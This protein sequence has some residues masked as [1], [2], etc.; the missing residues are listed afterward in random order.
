MRSG[1]EPPA[2][3]DT[4]DRR[5]LAVAILAAFVAFLDGTVITVALP[6][7]SAELGGGL[8]VQQWVVDAYLITL[9]ALI[10]LAGSLSDLWGRR[11]VLRLGLWG[12]ALT[13]LL[14]G[15]APT[16][17][18][19]I[20][21][22]ALQ[23]VAGA[24]LVPS[25][26][27][28]ITAAHRGRARATAIGVWTAWTSAAF[29][30]GPVLGGLLTDLASWRWVFVINLLPIAVT[31]VLM[32]GL[33]ADGARGTAPVDGW[34]AAL[35][36]L[37]LGGVVFALIEQ[38]NFGWGSPVV[39]VPLVLGML[40]L[41]G[42]IVREQRTAHPMMP[43]GLFRLRNFAVGNAATVAV[44]SA[45]SLGTF[46]VPIYL[47]Q[48]AGL[49]AT[50]AGLVLLPVTVLNIALSTWFG[51]L[52]GRFGSRWFM[53]AGPIVAAAGFLMLLAID[54]PFDF[55]GQALAGVLVF[56]LGLTITVAPLTSAI[57]GAVDE[58]RSGIASAINNA[59][60][61]VAG[62]VA[63]ALLGALIGTRVDDAWLDRGLILTA[64]LLIVGGLISAVGIT[65]RDAGHATDGASDNA[66]DAPDAPD[67]KRV[68][69]HG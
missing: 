43:L 29:L 53:A 20:I 45:L 15:L 30:A 57:L 31:L 50:Q 13:S 47:Q 28:L 58:S 23:G 55:V 8:P 51:S 61:R 62:L 63:I 1:Q 16:A 66:P 42:F 34:G 44:Y 36:A 2:V 19:L 39:L 48:G 17:E 27:A 18:F 24:M 22:R 35:G 60:S 52:A 6:A 14:C 5:V 38:A 3:S 37:G 4:L 9:G 68:P 65:N 40:S 54:E 67:A 46:V 64:G 33:R 56:G 11:F 41:A 21:A 59:V 69:R 12:F 32:R 10:L 49:G 26:L 7:I 25:S